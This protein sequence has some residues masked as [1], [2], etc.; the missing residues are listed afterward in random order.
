MLNMETL[1]QEAQTVPLKKKKHIVRYLWRSGTKDKQFPEEL[2]VLLPASKAYE[3]GTVYSVDEKYR[4]ES[5]IELYDMDG[6][7]D[8]VWTFSG[9]KE[10][11][12]DC[13]G[14]TIGSSDVQIQ[15]FWI[16]HPRIRK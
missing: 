6:N 10:D 11:S 14:H 2:C 3:E 16:W 4:A 1:H 9:W 12:V 13:K 5:A 7:V 8:G 15:G